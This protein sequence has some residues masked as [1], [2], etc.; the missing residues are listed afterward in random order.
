VEV[1]APEARGLTGAGPRTC[2][3]GYRRAFDGL[4]V[5]GAGRDELGG[6]RYLAAR[7]GRAACPE[8]WLDE[9][10]RLQACVR[11]G[12]RM[13][14]FRS[15]HGV[16]RGG[17]L[18]AALEGTVPARLGCQLILARAGQRLDALCFGEAP[19]RALVTVSGEGESA[20][21]TLATTHRIPF[22]K[23]GV[24]GGDRFTVAVDGVPLLDASLADLLV[25]PGATPPR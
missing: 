21:R 25:Y 4:Y 24:I 10:F 16:G 2:G 8:P 1:E 6:S 11:E 17:L 5:L 7:G 23:V 12:I 22:A 20:L 19:G 15:A 18:V 14:L 9:A 3:V 13:G